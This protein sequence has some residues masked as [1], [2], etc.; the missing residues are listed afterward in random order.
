MYSALKFFNVFAN[1]L[2]IFSCVL[3]F[4]DVGRD[5]W[6]VVRRIVESCLSTD[7][8]LKDF[9]TNRDAGIFVKFLWR[10]TAIANGPF[11][12]YCTNYTTEVQ[13]PEQATPMVK[14]SK[15]CQQLLSPFPLEM[16]IF[17][18]SQANNKDSCLQA[19]VFISTWNTNFHWQPS[20]QQILLPRN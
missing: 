20:E 19:F 16:L 4:P 2:R 5:C 3:C 14:E 12:Q 9:V 8:S 17:I 6:E 1:D 11:G 7:G 10:H 15:D 18:G 13:S